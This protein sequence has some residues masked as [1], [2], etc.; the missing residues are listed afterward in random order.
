MTNLD[1]LPV[2]VRGQRVR[3]LRQSAARYK[4]IGSYLLNDKDGAIVATLEYL[5][6][7]EKILREIFS[8]WLQNDTEH[9]WEH[10]V[11]CLRRC[12]LNGLADDVETA[13]GLRAQGLRR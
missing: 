11:Q 6:E 5:R 2:R 9:S 12:E 10:L 4:E 8:R 1:L 3:I 7:P 13:L